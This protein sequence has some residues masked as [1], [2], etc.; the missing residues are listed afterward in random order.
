MW[1]VRRDVARLFAGADGGERTLDEELAL[2][3]PMRIKEIKAELDVSFITF[4]MLPRC[5]CTRALPVA[6]R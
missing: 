5:T 1:S 3:K 4:T 2:V 6:A